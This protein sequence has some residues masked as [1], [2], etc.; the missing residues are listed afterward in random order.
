MK[1]KTIDAILVKNEIFTLLKHNYELRKI[2]SD[3]TKV[4]ES[5]INQWAIRRQHFQVGF[6]P[7]AN[8][9]KEY[10]GLTDADFFEVKT[11]L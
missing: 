10:S 9:I 7:I 6:T 4:R 5:T 1:K 11:E 3:K 8:I 2:I